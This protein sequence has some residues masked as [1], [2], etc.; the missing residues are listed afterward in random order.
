MDWF[1]AEFPKGVTVAG[2]AGEGYDMVWFVQNFNRGSAVVK[3][4]GTYRDIETETIFNGDVKM[5]AFSCLIL[6]EIR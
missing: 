4:N 1:K 2:R 6:E 5:E 3:L